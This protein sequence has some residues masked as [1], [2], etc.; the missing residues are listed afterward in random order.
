[1]RRL[2]VKPSHHHCLFFG[3][4]PHCPLRVRPLALERRQFLESF[5]LSAAL[6]TIVDLSKVGHEGRLVV[7]SPAVNHDL[8]FD[9]ELK[10]PPEQ[11]PWLW[12]CSLRLESTGN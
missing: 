6:L 1:M 12:K 10:L 4:I 7:L 8:Y 11:R 5:S 9:P 2:E 3:R